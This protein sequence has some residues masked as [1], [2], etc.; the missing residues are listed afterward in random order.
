MHGA[1]NS[2]GIAC[3]TYDLPQLLQTNHIYILN[4]VDLKIFQ[5]IH[6]SWFCKFDYHSLEAQHIST[7]LKH[8]VP[9]P[10]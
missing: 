1:H 9:P 8:L 4:E 2:W 7:E 6:F 5:R 10:V 3:F